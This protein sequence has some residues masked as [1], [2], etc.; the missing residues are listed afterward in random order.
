M[1]SY[2]FALSI[3]TNL[4]ISQLQQEIAATL[5]IEYINTN[6]DD[7]I[8]FFSRTLTTLELT[9]LDQYNTNHVPELVYTYT[10]HANLFPNQ[11]T[12]DTYFKLGSYA[13]VGKKKANPLVVRCVSYMDDGAVSY[14]VK[15]TDYLNAKV[16]CEATFTNT[17]PQIVSLGTLSNIPDYETIFE[18]H[19]K[20]IDTTN[21]YD[22]YINDV[23]FYM[24]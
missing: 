20:I 24:E 2:T 11:L 14:S 9:E 19:A 13:F 23:I 1:T 21:K 10:K 6:D 4:N 18:I 17:V 8:M 5:P 7:L 16:I 22:M 12:Y 3:Y 15:I